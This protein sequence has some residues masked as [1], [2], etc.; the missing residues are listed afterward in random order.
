[1]SLWQTTPHWILVVSSCD[2]TI[3]AQKI[4][5]NR[6]RVC[7]SLCIPFLKNPSFGFADVRKIVRYHFYQQLQVFTHPLW[8]PSVRP[9]GVS[10]QLHVTCGAD[11]F[12]RRFLQ[13]S[14]SIFR[15]QHKSGSCAT[16]NV[17]LKSD[18]CGLRV[19]F[20]LG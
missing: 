12:K 2:N 1:M 14:R 3:V 11:I 18:F 9:V 17:R 20:T 13:L 10:F 5:L 4:V 6:L 15:K 16:E 19:S 7:S 8:K